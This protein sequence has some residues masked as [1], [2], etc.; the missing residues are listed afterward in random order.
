MSERRSRRDWRSAVLRMARG[1]NKLT[2]AVCGSAQRARLDAERRH[3]EVLAAIAQIRPHAVPTCYSPPLGAMSDL[4]RISS[5][6]MADNE[7]VIARVVG[8]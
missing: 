5:L 4:E 2:D 6:E 3:A 1:I 8:P 7:E